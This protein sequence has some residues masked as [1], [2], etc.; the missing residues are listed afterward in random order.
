ML[1]KFLIPHSA[2]PVTTLDSYAQKSRIQ[3]GRKTLRRAPTKHKKSGF[4][5]QPDGTDQFVQGNDDSWMYK[6]STE[7]RP[8]A[9]EELVDEEV[10][11][12]QKLPISQ[13]PRV[14]MFPGMDPSVLK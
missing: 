14:A 8:S 4:G 3:L 2:L 10:V 7:Y 11:R 9:H 13:C 1:Q 12:P 6:D 5:D